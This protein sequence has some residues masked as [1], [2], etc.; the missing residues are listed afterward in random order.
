MT[1]KKKLHLLLRYL[2]L[3]LIGSSMALPF[4]WMIS[5][6]VKSEHEVFQPGFHLIPGVVK[7][8]N[9]HEVTHQIPFADYYW[10]SVVVSSSI[11]FG[12]VLTSAMAAFAFA[13]LR[14]PGRDRLFLFYL[15][16]LMVPGAVLMI[17]N[18]ILLSHLRLIDTYAGLILPSMFSAYGTFLLRQF[19]LTIPRELE[20]AARIDGCGYWGIFHHIAIPLSLPGIATLAIF[21][22]LGSWQS[23]FWPLI[24]TYSEELKTLPVGLSAFNRLYGTRYT[25]LMA[26]STMMLV[27]IVVVFLFGQR[28]FISGIRLGALKG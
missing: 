16:T 19:F 14:F 26:G 6:S 25:L 18:F 10:N 20:D 13:R 8:D 7:W 23:F 2:M 12:Q 3:I 5:T 15:A 24:I 9:Y 11:T 28:Y 21:A 17:P 4:I 27:P 1:V 22:F